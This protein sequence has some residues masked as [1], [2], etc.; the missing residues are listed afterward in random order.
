MIMKPT[1]QYPCEWLY[2]IIGSDQE[3]LEKAVNQT[4]VK[5]EYNI[6]FSRKSNQGKYTC[7]NLKTLVQ[8]KKD[9]DAIYTQLGNH[10]AIKTVL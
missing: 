10:P 6:W 4:L 3:S 1:I 7:L 5:T 9:R 8:N 2:K